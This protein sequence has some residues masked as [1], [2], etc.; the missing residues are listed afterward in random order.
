MAEF[1][2]SEGD[3]LAVERKVISPPTPFG[4]TLTYDEDSKKYTNDTMEGTYYVT[5]NYDKNAWGAP[6]TEKPVEPKPEPEPK[7][8]KEKESEPVVTTSSSKK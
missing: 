1:I 6:S 5:Y 2:L 4:L 8:T 3:A 7:A